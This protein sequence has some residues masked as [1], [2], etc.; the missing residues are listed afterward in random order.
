M[1]FFH[2]FIFEG[3]S[4]TLILFVFV[5]LFVFLVGAISAKGVKINS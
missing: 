1:D 3:F 4:V 5:C 2:T